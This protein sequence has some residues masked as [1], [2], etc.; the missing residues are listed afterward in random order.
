MAQYGL[1][2][3]K[4]KRVLPKILT[5]SRYSKSLT[6]LRPDSSLDLKIIV[7]SS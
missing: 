5:F 2:S 1:Y 6:S 3:P 7:L 4:T